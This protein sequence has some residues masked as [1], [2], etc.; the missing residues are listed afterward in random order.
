M[1]GKIKRKYPAVWKIRHRSGN[2]RDHPQRYHINVGKRYF[3]RGIGNIDN[4]A[5]NYD[6]KE[7]FYKIR[8]PKGYTWTYDYRSMSDKEYKKKIKR[9]NVKKKCRGLYEVDTPR[10]YVLHIMK[11]G[12]KW[13]V[14]KRDGEIVSPDYFDT[15]HDAVLWVYDAFDVF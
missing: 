5:G 9:F 3:I 14:T 13:L 10:G 12:S 11:N 15:K 6:K 4:C 2:I 1:K 8:V 7:H